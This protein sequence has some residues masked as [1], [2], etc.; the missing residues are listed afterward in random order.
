MEALLRAEAGDP[1]LNVPPVPPPKS[2]PKLGSSL[3]FKLPGG[4]TGA[5]GKQLVRAK[6]D[7]RRLNIARKK[8]NSDKREEKS[9]QQAET[10][11]TVAAAALT[12]LEASSFDLTKLKLPELY[13]LERALGVGKGRGKKPD[14]I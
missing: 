7:E 14:S 12:T 11:F 3:L 13:S 1:A 10:D 5:I 4:V 2:Q 6:E 9:A 8:L